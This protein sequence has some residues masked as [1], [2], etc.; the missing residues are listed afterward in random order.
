MEA[1]NQLLEIR[2]LF[3]WNSSSILFLIGKEVK[4]INNLGYSNYYYWV[5]ALLGENYFSGLLFDAIQGLPRKKLGSLDSETYYS[6]YE[7]VPLLN[8][9]TV[10]FASEWYPLTRLE[11]SVSKEIAPNIYTLLTTNVSEIFSI[12]KSIAYAYSSNFSKG[13]DIIA[14]WE[15]YL[16][17]YD[18]YNGF[19]FNFSPLKTD[20]WLKLEFDLLNILDLHQDARCFM[21]NVSAFLPFNTTIILQLASTDGI[22]EEFDLSYIVNYPFK[23]LILQFNLP[24]NSTVSFVRLCIK[25]SSSTA[26]NEWFHIQ[27]N[28]FLL[29]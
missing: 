13:F 25:V 9:R 24:S 11:L 4:P 1:L 10:I 22:L 23:P 3:G 21:F 20:G 29:L 27:L 16:W 18:L 5:A 12:A 28:D 15:N 26:T 8:N 17:S 19:S 6:G 7:K 2:S 14:G